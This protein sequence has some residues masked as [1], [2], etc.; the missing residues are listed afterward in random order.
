MWAGIVTV[1]RAGE[2]CGNCS[3]VGVNV[4]FVFSMAIGVFGCGT[5]DCAE[6]VASEMLQS[7]TARCCGVDNFNV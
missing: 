4:E 3:V 7:I 6:A 1:G 5:S 2:A